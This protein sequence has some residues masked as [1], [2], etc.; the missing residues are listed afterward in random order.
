MIAS[1]RHGDSNPN[2]WP[3][4]ATEHRRSPR[5]AA[6]PI[7]RERGR[8]RGRVRRVLLAEPCVAGLHQQAAAQADTAAG[9]E[10]ARAGG[11]DL[12]GPEGGARR[13]QRH[14]RHRALSARRQRAAAATRAQLAG[15]IAK[16]QADIAKMPRSPS[17]TNPTTL[18]PGEPLTATLTVT[19]YFSLVMALPLILFELY[20][21]VL[22]AFSPQERR[23]VMPLLSAFRFCLR[24][25]PL[26][27][28]W[29]SPHGGPFPAEL[30][31]PASS[32]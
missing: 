19:L 20:G 6:H 28:I 9:L 17:G 8:V 1:D 7:D 15:S 18:G 10:R 25:G 23:V 4:R 31:Q 27:V 24:P 3:R 5:R 21:F 12:A 16:L 22:P 32:T 30:Q 14:A 29:S 11:S 2:G 13:G 26:S